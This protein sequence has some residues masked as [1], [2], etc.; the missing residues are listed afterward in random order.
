M[1]FIET[2]IENIST[3]GCNVYVDNAGT[4]INEISVN[5]NDGEIE[6]SYK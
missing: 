2:I 6:V 5:A 1:I 4:L 3:E